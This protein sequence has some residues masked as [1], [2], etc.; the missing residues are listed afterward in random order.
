MSF[1][2]DLHSFTPR[3]MRDKI[4]EI[5][6]ELR[7]RS[8][9]AGSNIKLDEHPSGTVI[10]S[11][12]GG[13]GGGG[14]EAMYNGQWAVRL[15]NRALKV[16]ASTTGNLILTEDRLFAAVTNEMTVGFSNSGWTWCYLRIS[17]SSM[18]GIRLVTMSNPIRAYEYA[19]YLVDYVPLA[20]Y[21]TETG[22]IQLQY[23]P[24]RINRYWLA[25]QE[26]QSGGESL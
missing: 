15:E 6:A 1:I 25:E 14:G 24:V 20:L 13:G 8:L 2:P 10:S 19:D 7:K 9:V 12:S 26:E 5:I 21:S 22:V 18:P 23:G 3:A 4:N 16:P 11:M 17:M